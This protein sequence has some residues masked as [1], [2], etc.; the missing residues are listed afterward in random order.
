MAE[1]VEQTR[2]VS[3]ARATVN[4]RC[5]VCAFFHSR[6]DE[7]AIMLSLM[8]EG[9]NAG[10]RAVY[11]LDK[12][13]RTERFRRLAGTG[14]DTA[15]IEESGQL[16]VRSWENAYLTRRR[17][18]QH[19]M[20]ALIEDVANARANRG[21]GVTRVWA[22]M[23]WAVSDFPGVHDIVEY[24][25][26][27]NLMPPQYDMATVRV[28]DLDRFSASLVM[29]ILRT[30]SQVIVDGILRENLFY[31]PLDEFLRELSERSTIAH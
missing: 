20:I 19:A 24:E 30:H 28:Y 18:D 4:C 13:D 15:A 12:N 25:S 27:L 9:N 10:D 2:T 22:N 14:V 8:K 31:V 1:N 7:Y 17:F 11:I 23:E 21:T 6:E 16:K 29:D 26:R 5:H 3:L